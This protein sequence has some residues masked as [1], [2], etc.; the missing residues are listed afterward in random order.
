MKVSSIII[1]KIFIESFSINIY[2]S[3]LDNIPIFINNVSESVTEATKISILW[4]N[5][6]IAVKVN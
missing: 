6:Y 5:Y 1:K 4:F 2:K 3:M